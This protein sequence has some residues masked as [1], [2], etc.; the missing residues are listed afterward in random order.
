MQVIRIRQWKWEERL[1]RKVKERKKEGKF[2]DETKNSEY[3]VPRWYYVNIQNFFKDVLPL[4]TNYLDIFFRNLPLK[5]RSLSN[6]AMLI[7]RIL[8]QTV[9]SFFW[10]LKKQDNLTTTYGLCHNCLLPKTKTWHVKKKKATLFTP[11]ET[12]GIPF[13][14]FITQEVVFLCIISNSIDY[15]FHT[16]Y[17]SSS[18]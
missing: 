9:P 16:D 8:L 5:N 14:P 10:S 6:T 3:S 18:W 1:E 4:G 7:H 12:F 11:Q 13:N 15:L 17:M 2:V